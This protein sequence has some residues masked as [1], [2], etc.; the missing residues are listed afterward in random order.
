VDRFSRAKLE[1]P[2]ADVHVLI[3]PAA[4]MHFYPAHAFVEEGLVLEVDDAEV[5]AQ[6]TI[7]PLQQIEVESGGVTHCVVV[8]PVKALGPLEQ[9]DA[10]NDKPPGTDQPRNI[11]KEC[12]DFIRLEIPDARSGK[13]EDPRG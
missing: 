3:D 10:Q 8:G 11:T 1:T 7:D 9:V 6:F 5:C 2:V 12:L 13:K 4:Q